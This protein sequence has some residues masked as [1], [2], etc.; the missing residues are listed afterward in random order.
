MEPKT[1]VLQEAKQAHDFFRAYKPHPPT[2]W[3]FRGQADSAWPLIP[4][5]GRHPFRLP[6]WRH[7]GRFRAWSKAAVA[8]DSSLPPNDWERL[9]IAQHFG[10]ATCLLDW[11]HNPLV[12]LY[13]CCSELVAQ[14]GAVYCYQ[15][16]AFVKESVLPCDESLSCNG[17]GFIPRALS[18]RILNQRAVFTVHSPADQPLEAVAHPFLTDH[19]SLAKL[20][21]PASLKPEL[22]D[23]LDVY[24]INRS[25][26]FPDLEGLS[27]HVNW[28]TSCIAASGRQLE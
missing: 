5:A 2:G 25:T 19:P 7:I 21:V 1:Y 15:P 24:G 12:A 9:A 11:T 10:L 3:W 8:Y 28:E 26:L 17:I 14:D 6:E 22:L 13:F 18:S 27:S 23:I 20:V 16:D 4:K